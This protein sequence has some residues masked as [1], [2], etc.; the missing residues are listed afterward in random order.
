MSMRAAPFRMLSATAATMIS[1]RVRGLRSFHLCCVMR[2]RQGD[3]PEG[4]S[5]HLPGSV[6]GAAG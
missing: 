1:L 3:G 6:E 5:S 4:A 2:G